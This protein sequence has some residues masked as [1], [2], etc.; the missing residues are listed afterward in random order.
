MAMI[1]AATLDPQANAHAERLDLER[2]P[3]RHVAFGTWIHFCLGHQLARIEAANALQALFTRWP[4]L[5]LAVDASEIRWNRR[6]GL[7]SIE[8]LPVAV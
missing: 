1:A 3:N 8:K 6:P 2:R 7:R 5:N 4:Q